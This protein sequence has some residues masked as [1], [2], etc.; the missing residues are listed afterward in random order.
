MLRNRWREFNPEYTFVFIGSRK[1]L[2]KYVNELFEINY[3]DKIKEFSKGNNS[4][5]FYIPIGN[6]SV[7]F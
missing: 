5:N 3:K 7:F 2:Y 4:D 6:Q 1:D